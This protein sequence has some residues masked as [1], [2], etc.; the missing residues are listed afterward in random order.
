MTVPNDKGEGGGA[1][2]ENTPL[3]APSQQKRMF[4]SQTV[5]PARLKRE[6]ED[7]HWVPLNG[8]NDGDGGAE[9]SSKHVSGGKQLQ[10]IFDS[11]EQKDANITNNHDQVQ[12]KETVDKNGGSHVDTPKLSFTSM[13]FRHKTFGILEGRGGA[14]GQRYEAVMLILILASILSFVLGTLFVPK[15]NTA[16]YAATACGKVC[17]ALWFGNYDDN[18]L[19]FLGLGPTSVLELLVIAVFTV[20]YILRLWTADLEDYVYRGFL[21]RLRYI[22]TFYSLVDLASTVPFYVDIYLSNINVASSQFLRMFRLFRMMKV[23]GRYLTAL[24]LFDDVF[25]AQKS[26]LGTALFVGATTWLA[27]SSLYYMAERRNL[28][29][30]YCSVPLCTGFNDDDKYYAGADAGPG[31]DVDTSLCTMD[32]WGFVD[33]TA[34]GCPPL[35]DDMT[36]ELPCW[37]QYRSIPSSLYFSLLNLFGEY[38]LIQ[39]HSPIGK[40]VGTLT[41]VVAV[42][43]FALPAGIVGNGFE[44]LLEQR[45]EAR[46][47]ETKGQIEDDAYA[48]VQREREREKEMWQYRDP[49]PSSLYNFFHAPPSDSASTS[50]G[51]G[52]HRAS[53]SF[54]ITTVAGMM[55]EH[56]LNATVLLATLT[57]MLST[58]KPYF[59]SMPQ[60]LSWLDTFELVAV[61]MFSLDY[62]GK[63][64]T[65]TQ[66]PYFHGWNHGAVTYMTSFLPLVDLLSFAPFWIAGGIWGWTSAASM[67]GVKVLRSLRLFRFERYTKAFTTFDNVLRFN[68]DVLLVTGIAA[69]ILWIFFSAVMYLT[70]RDNL[71]AE[72]ASYYRTVPGAMW[73]TLLNLSGESPLCQYS[74]WGK[75]TTGVMGLFA[76]G[77]FGI[78]IGILGAGFEEL[79]AQENEHEA[80]EDDEQCEKLSDAMAMEE[81]HMDPNRGS[82]VPMAL[83]PQRHHLRE[84]SHV[85]SHC[86]I[87]VHRFVNG[88]G[89]TVAAYFEGLIYLL[90]LITVFIGI[91]Q[92]VHAHEET[93]H[94]V[95]TVAVAI[96]SVEYLM[97]FYGAPADPQW[98]AL[99]TRSKLLAR[100]RYVVSFYSIIDLCAILPMYLAIAMPGTWVDRRGDYLRMLRLMRLLKLDKYVPS[101][102]LI[103]DV[104]RLKR[105]ALLTTCYAAGT[106]WIIFAGLLYLFEYQDTSNGIDGVPLYGK[107]IRHVGVLVM[108]MGTSILVI[109]LLKK[110]IDIQ[111]NRHPFFNIMKQQVVTEIVPWLIGFRRFWIVWCT[112]AFT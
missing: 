27:V 75:V 40:V 36:M 72:V 46:R 1:A 44:D 16:P 71:D 12:M 2:K 82:M 101:I 52:S 70:E 58:T 53:S 18:A 111:H 55:R 31:P 67:T 32:A 69:V 108:F 94:F 100:I 110:D 35:S 21:G 61:V 17:D 42:A 84:S 103:D 45:R 41:A 9:G 74:V 87:Q 30:I 7:E 22:P 26:I 93:L 50:N 95:E 76:T 5:S 4:P 77:L 81:A 88:D 97:R 109:C 78:P 91:I 11:M 63:L 47:N 62:V 112:R 83:G 43:V 60:M 23:E 20:D 28:D 3:L 105:K 89:S 92:T 54:S 56:V 85:A 24:T 8:S 68:A 90:I 25:R 34:A 64:A 79:V 59:A 80:K 37:N 104:L 48:S 33:C 57:F 106:L 102:T 15:Y 65:V 73:V 96:F 66:N 29:M 38:P 107:F 39:Q 6:H 13:T 86:E 14:W 19:A 49:N 51:T 99:A 10:G 98:R